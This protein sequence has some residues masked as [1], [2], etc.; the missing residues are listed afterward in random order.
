[1]SKRN[2]VKINKN[3]FEEF[4]FLFDTMKS[5]LEVLKKENNLKFDIEPF[6]EKLNRDFGEAEIFI[7]KLAEK[8]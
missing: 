2:Y 7:K 3:E 1:M 6:L 5:H 4:L 8:F